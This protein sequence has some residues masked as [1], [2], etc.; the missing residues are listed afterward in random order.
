MQSAGITRG[1]GVWYT[2]PITG[3]IDLLAP[4]TYIPFMLPP[5]LPIYLYGHPVLRKKARP[6]KAAGDDLAA[7]GGALTQTMHNAGGI[8]LAATQVGD[9]RRV[10]VVDVGETDEELRGSPPLVMVNPEVL[11]E[12]GTNV[13]EEGCLSIPEI[14]G[15]VTRAETI[16]VRFRDLEFRQRELTV[17]GLFARVILHEVDHLNGVLFIDRLGATRQRLLKGRLNRI[18]RGEVPTTYP[19]VTDD[20]TDV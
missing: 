3:S 7:F 6:V 9:L 18:R 16:Q 20:V 11:K 2:N 10:I 1:L 8:G 19:V 13:R 15:D 14:R 12:S 4:C 17:S 5:L